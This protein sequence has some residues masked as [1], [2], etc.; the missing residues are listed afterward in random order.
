MLHNLRVKGVSVTIVT[1]HSLQT[2]D[3][4]TAADQEAA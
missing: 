3:V 4:S 2:I 1:K